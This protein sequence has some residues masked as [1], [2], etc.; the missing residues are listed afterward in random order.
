MTGGTGFFGRWMLE[1]FLRANDELGLGAQAVV[2]ARDPQRFAGTAPHVAGHA[3]VTF[4]PGDVNSFAFPDLDC[5]HILHMATETALGSSATASFT[6]AVSGTERVLDLAA[7]T[8][9]RRLLLTSSGA[10]YGPQPTDCERLSED[11]AGAP[12]PQDVTSGYGHGKR[13]AEFL[14]S[15]AAATTDLEVMIARCFAFV[16]PL[17][18]LDGNFAIGNF[19]RDAL[20][21]DRIDVAGDGTAR[22]SY[23]YAADLALWL[24]TI[25]FRGQS[26]RPYNV[27][28]EA[29]LSIAALASLVGDVLR[30]GI[31]V[32]IAGAAT[33][34]PPSRYVPATTR[35]HA[36]LDLSD[37]IGLPD[38]VLRT[39]NWYSASTGG[40]DK[41]AVPA[42]SY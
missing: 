4:H 29:D 34:A 21:R 35:A 33:S 11:Y 42:S 9:A 40:G 39:A 7:A 5:S 8:G 41:L 10:V 32:Q 18:P 37:R 12:S 27:G 13:A 26:T 3:A 2:L 1:S 6:T 15:A 36:E 38:A 25:L 24:W 14:C 22:R 28:S 17:L 19:I 31:P 16:G 23:L 30:P 20:Y